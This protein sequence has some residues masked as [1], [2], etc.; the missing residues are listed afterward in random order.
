MGTTISGD[1]GITFPDASTQSKAV[2]QATPFAVTASAIAGAELRLPEATANGVNYVAVKAPNTLSANTTWTLPTADG[3]NGQYLQTN[4]AGQLSFSSVV[5]PPVNQITAVASGTI[6]TGASVILNADGT[7]SAVSGTVPGTGSAATAATTTSY[8]S[9]AYDAASNRVVVAYRNGSDTFGYAVVGTISG[10]TI[11]FGTPVLF[12]NGSS[13]LFIKVCYVTAQQRILIAFRGAGGNVFV[14][15]GQVSG[16]SITFGTAVSSGLPGTPYCITEVTGQSRAVVFFDYPGAAT[17][18]AHSITLSGSTSSWTNYFAQ[19]TNTTSYYFQI[20]SP[21]TDK[22][23]LAYRDGN[24]SQNGFCYHLNVNSSTGVISAVR[25]DQFTSGI[26]NSFNMCG[27][28]A[29]NRFFLFYSDNSV[30]ANVALMRPASVGASTTTLGSVVT[31]TSSLTGYVTGNNPFYNQDENSS[32]TAIFVSSGNRVYVPYT[33]S[34][35]GIL[36]GTVS[37]TGSTSTISFEPGVA[38]SFGTG[39]SNSIGIAYAGTAGYVVLASSTTSSAMNAVVTNIGLTTLTAI[40]FVGFSA[41]SYTNG[42]TATVQTVGAV[43][44]NVSGLTPAQKYYVLGDGSLSTTA[45]TRN[46]YAGLSTSATSILVK[47]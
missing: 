3:T 28:P 25:S 16:T 24:N 13:T 31:I 18:V 36:S 43:S 17:F 1:T 4:G 34:G 38:S 47:G 44:T 7:V 21:A 32:P 26:L 9:A 42:Q 12:Y 14:I 39:G 33:R 41:A 22:V 37:G 29:N 40:N 35:P 27:D 5:I 8:V 11:S 15:A 19:A 20:C 45:D 10:T 2:S 46:V 23:M 30:G 6:A